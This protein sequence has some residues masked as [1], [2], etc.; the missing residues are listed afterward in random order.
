[1]IDRRIGL[2][3]LLAA[4][5]LFA[6]GCSRLDVHIKLNADGS[7]TITERMAFSRTQ[8]EQEVS[9]P[10]G[11]R[12][13]DFL[14]KS[15]A[16]KRATQMGAGCKL[17]R[18]EVRKTVDAGIEAAAVYT[19]PDINDLRYLPP[20]FAASRQPASV[21]RIEVGPSYVRRHAAPDRPGHMYVD[22]SMQRAFPAPAQKPADK[23][24]AAPT[25][26]GLQALRELA[27][28]AKDLLKD[29]RIRITFEAYSPLWY[30]TYKYPNVL[31]VP[32]TQSPTGKYYLINCSG[33]DLDA[34]GKKI[35][36]NQ[37]A[38]L[39]LLRG[40]YAGANI[41]RHAGYGRG[42]S[43]PKAPT[44]YTPEM[45]YHTRRLRF[46]ASDYHRKKYFDGKLVSQGGNV[47]NQD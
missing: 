11:P 6:T 30:G 44:F 27:P 24:R 22:F 36:D 40:D 33:T 3:T 17:V 19:I 42:R 38:M 20:F 16:T 28:V 8:L 12:L 35:L 45:T 13:K 32:G 34:L 39:E 7:A 2:L 31:T 41:Q 47:K 46:A 1:M 25:P 18:H 5:A 23:K 4:V 14:N 9:L 26:A 21:L 29:S 10:G 43:N 15:R 37:E